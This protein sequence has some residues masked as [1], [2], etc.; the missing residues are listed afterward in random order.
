MSRSLA[1]QAELQQAEIKRLRKELDQMISQRCEA[2]DVSAA[3]CDSMRKNAEL[4]QPHEVVA[5]ANKEAGDNSPSV[6]EIQNLIQAQSELI[7][8]LRRQV[9]DMNETPPE[10]AGAAPANTVGLS[11]L[12]EI[13]VGHPS[14]SVSPLSILRP[15]SPAS[16]AQDDAARPGFRRRGAA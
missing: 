2:A 16:N 12:N 5:V 9:A 4:E 15:G 3:E 10:A 14:V 1:D 7:A 8:K 6:F 13:A 11:S